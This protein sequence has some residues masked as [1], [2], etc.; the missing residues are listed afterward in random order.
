MNQLDALIESCRAEEVSKLR[1]LWSDA[2]NI[3]R[4]LEAVREDMRASGLVCAIDPQCTLDH[5]MCSE[6]P[7]QYHTATRAALKEQ[8]E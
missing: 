8:L 5:G 7:R 1:I 6:C 2:R 3:R 4:I